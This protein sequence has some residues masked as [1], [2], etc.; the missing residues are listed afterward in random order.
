MVDS[1]PARAFRVAFNRRSVLRELRDA[2]LQRCG[3]EEVHWRAHGRHARSLPA[4]WPLLRLDRI[5]VR[6]VAGHRP[7]PMP[8]RPWTRLPDHAPLAAELERVAA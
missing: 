4:R 6:G 5:Y 7:L 1:A 8:R 2:A 3:L